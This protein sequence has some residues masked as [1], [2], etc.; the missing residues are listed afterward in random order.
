MNHLLAAFPFRENQNALSVCECAGQGWD[1]VSFKMYSEVNRFPVFSLRL[2]IIGQNPDLAYANEC[3]RVFTCE[4]GDVGSFSVEDA[5]IELKKDESA[6]YMLYRGTAVPGL[7]LVAD[8]C[9]KLRIGNYY[10][11]TFYATADIQSKLKLTLSNPGLIL[12]DVPY[13][14]P[15]FEQIVYLDGEI[16]SLPADIFETRKQ[17]ESGKDTITYQK[18]TSRKGVYIYNFPSYIAELLDALPMHQNVTVSQGNQIYKALTKK[19]KASIT[20][21]NCCDYDAE[22][23]I[24]VR[25]TEVAGGSCA[26]N[27]AGTLQDVEIPDGLPDSCEVDGDF[28]PTEETLCLPF[29]QVPP[30][31]EPPITTPV[32]TPPVGNPCPPQ[33]FINSSKTDIQTCDNPFITAG[34]R[35]KKRITRVVADGNCGQV[36]QL[37]YEDSCDVTGVG[38]TISEIS[39]D[40]E[41]PPPPVGTPPV[42]SPPVGTPPPS[43]GR[44]PIYDFL[45]GTT[46]YGFDRNAE[47]G[48]NNDWIE[49][50]EAFR[51]SWGFGITGISLWIPWEEYELTPGVYQTAALLRAINYCNARSLSLSCVF[52]ARRN[53]PDGFLQAG[54]IVKGSL[55]KKYVEGGRVYPSYGCDRTLALMQGAIKSIAT[56]LKT[57]SRKFYMAPYGGYTGEVIN[58]VLDN[59]T[60]TSQIGDFSDDNLSRFNTWCINRGLATPG[61][62]PIIH[63][64]NQ[65]WPYPDWSQARG[66]EFG[67]FMTYNIKKFYKNF[68]DAVKS[69]DATIPCLYFY[70][71]AG[72]IQ[73]RATQNAAMDYIADSG[74]GMYG[75]D[76]DGL[77]GANGKIA[78]NAVNLGTFPNGISAMEFDPDDTSTWRYDHPG[79]PL[80]YGGINPQ[81]GQVKVYMEQLYSKG[82]QVIHTAMSF[83]PDE[84]R[85][86][87]PTLKDMRQTYIGKPYV[88]PVLTPANTV[89]VEVTKYRQNIDLLSG[90]D[91]YQKYVKY[92]S[93][94]YW[95][96]VNPP[97]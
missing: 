96:G 84:I 49:R 25:E 24:P 82:A 76:G 34:G 31:L 2:P 47:H 12:G 91:V 30:S 43:S 18:L 21:N 67:R 29:G 45:F 62:P 4:G 14:A 53:E 17:E 52:G 27:S 94:D 89:E 33:G 93:N 71:A 41:T 61:V 81:Y 11:E 54:E 57:Y 92:V 35:F 5:G 48:I 74:D 97:A 64:S 87:E 44:T 68:T 86:W 56:V 55:G 60:A 26:P 20:Q 51:Y 46:G 28:E 22:I 36:T 72:N 66:V 37:T 23:V 83:S 6:Y 3:V 63:G 13:Q 69:V 58:H 78:V 38:H 39:C 85:G 70:A 65:Q 79:V 7:K 19:A 95:G 16:C 8:Q 15:G 59:G 40:T 32:G 80:P 42:G 77:Y 73:L 10:S 50:I 9:Y 1:P 88:R 90:I 75:S